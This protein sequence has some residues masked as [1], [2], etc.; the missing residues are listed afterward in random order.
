MYVLILLFM[1]LEMIIDNFKTCTI[2]IYYS[3]DRLQFIFVFKTTCFTNKLLSIHLILAFSSQLPKNIYSTGVDSGKNVLYVNINFISVKYLHFLILCLN[4]E[5]IL[6]S[7]L[8]F[9]LFQNQFYFNL[10]IILIFKNSSLLLFL[11][12][13]IEGIFFVYFLHFLCNFVHL[14]VTASSSY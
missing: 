12:F 11:I 13:K 3:I 9:Q 14:L 1:I 5:N 4:L 7:Y 8:F 6:L 10:F 2:L